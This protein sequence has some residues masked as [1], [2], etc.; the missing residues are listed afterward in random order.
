MSWLVVKSGASYSSSTIDRLL[1]LHQILAKPTKNF[2]ADKHSSLAELSLT[3]KK[4]NLFKFF[5]CIPTQTIKLQDNEIHS[6]W[7]FFWKV[8]SIISA[9][10]NEV[11]QSYK[12]IDKLGRFTCGIAGSLQ[13]K[14]SWLNTA[15][16]GLCHKCVTIVIDAPSVV[17]VTLQIV[18]SLTIVIDDAG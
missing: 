7:F 3:K 6:N 18:A 2:A 4:V 13:Y 16:C 12:L 8:K 14:T 9:A 11:S 10:N 5:F 15:A 1:S 17:K